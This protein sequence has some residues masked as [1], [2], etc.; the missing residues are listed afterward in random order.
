MVLFQFSNCNILGKCPIDSATPRHQQPL[1]PWKILQPP[2]T[3]IVCR[4]IAVIDLDP[5]VLSEKRLVLVANQWSPCIVW[6]TLC[7][8]AIT[9]LRAIF[10]ESVTQCQ[11]AT[12]HKSKASSLFP[13]CT[14]KLH[15]NKFLFVTENVVELAY[16]LPLSRA[17]VGIDYTINKVQQK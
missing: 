1:S 12:R 17:F 4:K 10:F 3:W 13:A 16:D 5:S 7:R 6:P 2:L 9:L 11:D 14:D 8:H 15:D